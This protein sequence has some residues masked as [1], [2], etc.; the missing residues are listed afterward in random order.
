MGAMASPA[1]DSSFSVTYAKFNFASLEP[2]DNGTTKWSNVFRSGPHTKVRL[3]QL[4]RCYSLV[5]SCFLRA[6]CYRMKATCVLGSCS[7]LLLAW[8]KFTKLLLRTQ[9]PFEPN[10]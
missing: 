2:F 6:R 9:E 8:Q 1:T 10:L 7:A 4:E 3:M 5:C